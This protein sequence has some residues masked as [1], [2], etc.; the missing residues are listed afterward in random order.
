MLIDIQGGRPVP[1]APAA[2]LA[3][4]CKELQVRERAQPVSAALEFIGTGCC[5]RKRKKIAC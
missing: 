5:K 4:G 2:L 3:P 1:T